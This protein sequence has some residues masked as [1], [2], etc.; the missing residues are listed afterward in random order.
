MST[1][2]LPILKAVDTVIAKANK[3]HTGIPDVVVVLGS[4]GHSRKGQVHGHFYPESWTK[5]DKPVL[6][7]LMLSGESLQR[8]AEATLGTIL[9]ELAH[10]YNHANSIADTS[11]NHRYHNAKFR[12]TGESFGIE[13]EQAPTIGWSVTTVPAATLTTYAKEVD[14][15]RA[16]LVGYRVPNGT[17]LAKKAKKFMMGCPE[18]G[19]PVATTKKWFEAHGYDLECTLHNQMFEF[20]EED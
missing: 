8:G 4:A 16:A 6:H 5:E 7:E 2:T 18:C 17:R 13:L 20:Y 11:N 10:A 14:A 1:L 12:K 9:H 15:L 3:L 19:E